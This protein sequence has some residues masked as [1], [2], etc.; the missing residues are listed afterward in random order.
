MA[1]YIWVGALSV[2]APMQVWTLANCVD[3]A[4]GKSAFGLIGGGAILGWVAGGLATR[5][6]ADRF[7]TENMLLWVAATLIASAVMVW[8]VWPSRPRQDD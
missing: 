6:I 2:L 1:I 8:S 7:G 4:R 3:H 5:E